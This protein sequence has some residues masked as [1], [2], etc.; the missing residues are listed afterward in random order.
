MAKKMINDTEL[1]SMEGCVK[2]FLHEGRS[3]TYD[4][5]DFLVNIKVIERHR[6]EYGERQTYIYTISPVVFDVLEGHYYTKAS[7]IKG[8]QLNGTL[9]FDEF[10][11]RFLTRVYRLKDSHSKAEIMDKW[12]YRILAITAM[13]FYVPKINDVETKSKVKKK[14]KK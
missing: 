12:F 4:F 5:V 11:A 13:E 14:V 6:V 10:A 7:R 1:Y 2:E 8:K 9:Y 3:T